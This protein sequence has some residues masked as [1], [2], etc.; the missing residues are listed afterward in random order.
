MDL[1]RLNMANGTPAL[2]HGVKVVEIR[3]LIDQLGRQATYCK[4]KNRADSDARGDG[5]AK[6]MERGDVELGW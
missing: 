1:G 4:S 2:N 6:R 5:Q 3:A